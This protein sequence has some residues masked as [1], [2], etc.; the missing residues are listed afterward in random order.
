MPTNAYGVGDHFDLENSHVIP[1]LVRRFHE[2]KLEKKSHV[3]I[4]GSGN[5]LREFIYVDDLAD[6][7]LFLMDNYDSSELVNVGTEDEISIKDLAYK[8]AK[9]TDYK[10]MIKFDTSKPDGMKRKGL[11]SQKLNKMGWR[12]KISLD[13]GIERTYQYF[14]EQ[15]RDVA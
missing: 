7:L 6:A 5:V 2:A 14:L 8:I 12:P 9:V 1:A 3:E 15:Y 4:W 13:E 11:D 10:G